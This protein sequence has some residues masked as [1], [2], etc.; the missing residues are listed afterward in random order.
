M[1]MIRFFWWMIEPGHR[2]QCG[3]GSAAQA[4]VMGTILWNQCILSHLKASEP[5]VAFQSHEVPLFTERLTLNIQVGHE[6]GHIHTRVSAQDVGETT[7]L[8]LQQAGWN[9]GARTHKHVFTVQNQ[10][11]MIS[12]SFSRFIF[13]SWW[14]VCWRCL[15]V[16]WLVEAENTVTRTSALYVLFGHNLRLCG[17]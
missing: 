9:H 13:L 17:L 10:W 14:P 3:G 12:L 16:C 11:W 15:C 7:S 4:N 6:H 1:L 8:W 2:G 5:F